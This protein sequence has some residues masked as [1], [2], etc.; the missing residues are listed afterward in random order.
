MSVLCIYLYVYTSKARIQV[1]SVTIG[2][3]ALCT[4]SEPCC[5]NCP[6][7]I[8]W[9]IIWNW[10]LKWTWHGIHKWKPLKNNRKK[11]NKCMPYHIRI[12]IH[13]KV[14]MLFICLNWEKYIS[15]FDLDVMK[16]EQCVPITCVTR[17]L[18]T[19]RGQHF[20]IHSNVKQACIEYT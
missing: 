4:D 6:L 8:Q 19:C 14:C 18:K 10:A 15:L 12:H 2:K 1:D 9:V 16:I 13:M 20:N 11:I 3:Q 5:M 17:K 7:C